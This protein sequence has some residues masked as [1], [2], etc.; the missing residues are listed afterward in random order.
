MLVS[1]LEFDIIGV[2][3]AAADDAVQQPRGGVVVVDRLRCVPFISE[4]D[5]TMPTKASSA[6]SMRSS[7]SSPSPNPISSASCKQLYGFAAANDGGRG[8]LL[9]ASVYSSS[10]SSV[11][12]RR[13]SER[14]NGSGD[15]IG[16]RDVLAAE[17]VDDDDGCG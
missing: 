2:A 17:R 13:E 12:S 8:M 10:P 11:R 6:P 4:A 5:A 7:P 16:M 3:V 15:G 14:R 9:A 1:D